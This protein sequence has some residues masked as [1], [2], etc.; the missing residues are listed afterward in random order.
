M[1]WRPEDG[2]VAVTGARGLVPGRWR[3]GR[4]ARLAGAGLVVVLACLATFVLWSLAATSQL[5]Q[6]VELTSTVADGYQQVRTGAATEAAMER[7]YRLE[8]GPQSLAYFAAAADQLQAGL[9]QVQRHGNAQDR[10]AVAQLTAAHEGY[11]LAVAG[12]FAAVDRGDAPAAVRLA[13]RD[14]APWAVA[15]RDQAWDVAESHRA[16]SLRDLAA[17][18]HLQ[19][20]SEQLAPV[21]FLGG[22]M[23]LIL[24]TMVLR[25]YR[26]TLQR[27]QAQALHDALHDALTGLPNRSLLVDRC[28]QAL[29]QG[30]RQGT[31]SG[32]LLLDLDRFKE[33]NDALGQACGDA[34]LVQV[35]TRL[36]ECIREMDTVA[37]LGADEYAVLMPAVGSLPAALSAA[38]RLR[39]AIESP[40]RL[41]DVD[42]DVDVE[43]SVGVAVSDS[44]MTDAATLLQQADSAMYAA[45]QQH[46]GVAPYSVDDESSSP[47][48]LA[49]LGELR[50][51]MSRGELVLHYQPKV[52]L[53]TG[54]VSGVEALVRWQHPERGLLPPDDFI[55]LAERTGLIGPL[56]DYVL[57]AAFAQARL[58]I[59]VGRPMTIAVN[60]S[61]RNLLD[62]H[63]LDQ[64]RAALDQHGVPA[65]R[66]VLEVTETAIIAE[67][68][69]TLDLLTR[70]SG[71]GV[72]LSIDDFG[73]GYT[74]LAQL[75]TLPVTELKIDRSFV[76]AMTEH[77]SQAMIVHSLIELGHNLGLTMVAE[78]VETA[79]VMAA[80]RAYGCDVAQGYYLTRP[81]PIGAFDDWCATWSGLDSLGDRRL[82]RRLSDHAATVVQQRRGTPGSL[83]RPLAG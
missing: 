7:E 45:K 80:L 23:M 19:R 35:G 26:G 59:D 22:L 65:S 8:P 6:R 17:M 10:M 67:P 81:L 5:E 73:A 61:G 82:D 75:S 1:I 41:G 54:E 30:R 50:R 24:F 77:R 48:R 14:V 18:R 43:V 34:L 60:V 40:F 21:M 38:S 39:Q 55:P 36:T 3:T 76:S 79:A 46:L 27:Q 25:G 72:R 13:V 74:S 78:G 44:S 69:R 66:L 58:W 57:D 68:R 16:E 31:V 62:E 4:A 56:T 12:M 28:D 70:L 2:P 47:Q 32:L 52:S 42:V 51:G 53:S 15:L 64:V 49:M 29:R 71:L 20:L 63:L 9:D 37:R 33:V 11:R 83:P